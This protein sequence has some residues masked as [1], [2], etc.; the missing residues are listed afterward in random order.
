MND[1]PIPPADEKS[2]LHTSLLKSLQLT[3]TPADPVP[4]NPDGSLTPD[5]GVEV[6]SNIDDFSQGSGSLADQITRR[7]VAP[8]VETPV[9][10]P[11]TP[12]TI[13][14]VVTPVTPPVTP[15]IDPIVTPVTPDLPKIKVPEM[16]KLPVDTTLPPPPSLLDLSGLDDD[17]AEEVRT[18]LFAERQ[19]PDK[20][21]GYGKKV[22]EFLQKHK[23]FVRQQETENPDVSFD[24]NNA[25]YQ[26]FL[27]ANRPAATA[28]ERKRLDRERLMDETAAA[29]EKRMSVKTRKLEEEIVQLK[30]T[31][32]VEKTV[33]DYR[34]LVK[35]IMPKDDDPISQEAVAT[36]SG[37]AVDAG[38]EFLLLSS[39]LK[40]YDSGNETHKWLAGFIQEQ[41]ELYQKSGHPSL[42]RGSKS[43]VPRAKFNSLSADER[44]KHFTF[45]DED[46]LQIIA[47]SAKSAAEHH[48]NVERDRLR[49][50]GYTRVSATPIAPVTPPLSVPDVSPRATPT[51]STPGNVSD[52]N[53]G[54]P[55]QRFMAR[56]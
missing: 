51:V 4:Q 20:Y 32:L 5:T 2:S 55:F 15:P 25:S 9:V 47:A 40:P 53:V 34:S 21:A 33:N 17:D 54:D 41:G 23:Q 37:K 13:P 22:L 6:P 35:E 38:R 49:K 52:G 31:P 42:K 24:T 14:P 16:P 48:A 27:Q 7:V 29:A 18:A 36:M 3:V 19:Y 45:S 39:S 44:G 56:K 30:A 46:V 11:V 50:A 8:P 43:F 28:S 10:P 1:T 26:R 12:P